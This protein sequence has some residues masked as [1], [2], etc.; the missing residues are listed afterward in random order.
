MRVE[1]FRIA[2]EN[3][4]KLLKE[5][6]NPK[7]NVA[8]WRLLGEIGSDRCFEVIA[9]FWYAQQVDRWKPIHAQNVMRSMERDLFPDIGHLPLE[10]IDTHSCSRCRIAT[11]AVLDRWCRQRR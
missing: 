3:A 7:Y 11:A 2:L 6:R 4:H 5:G 9:R 10:D 1:M 8:N